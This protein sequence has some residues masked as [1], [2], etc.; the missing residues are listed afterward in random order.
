MNYDREQKRK[1]KS[2]LS[3]LGNLRK[4]KRERDF[5]LPILFRPSV[6]LCVFPETRV[7]TK[8]SFF[9]LNLSERTRNARLVL[10]KGKKKEGSDRLFG[11]SPPEQIWTRARFMASHVFA[12]GDKAQREE[13]DPFDLA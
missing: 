10:T 5:S 6:S 12:I 13:D 8:E 3:T 7:L 9:S 4:K 1:W 2:P 11:H